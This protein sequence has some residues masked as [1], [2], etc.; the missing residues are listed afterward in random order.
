MSCARPTSKYIRY[1]FRY[2]H[3]KPNCHL[4]LGLVAK[5]KMMHKLRLDTAV[6]KKIDFELVLIM[7][8]SPWRNAKKKEEE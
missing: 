2:I 5:L 8:V 1:M 4:G 3:A 7:F 6:R